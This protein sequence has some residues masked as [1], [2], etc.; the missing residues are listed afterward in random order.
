MESLREAE[1]KYDRDLQATYERLDGYF[2]RNERDDAIRD[3]EWKSLKQHQREEREQFFADGRAAFKTVRNEVYRDIREQFREDWRTTTP[4]P[5][6][7]TDRE[8][9][10]NWKAAIIDLQAEVF[11]KAKQEAFDDLRARRGEEYVELLAEQKDARQD[12]RDAQAQG[13]RSYELLDIIT[14]RQSSPTMTP[15]RTKR[16]TRMSWTKPTRERKGA[17]K[18]T[19]LRG[20][21]LETMRACAA[22]PMWSG[23]SGLG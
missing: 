13:R 15:T 12:L 21:T 23:I 22:A 18:P 20:P 4:P 1:R 14:T 3:N 6:P 11:D 17:R 16:R 9:L 2:S 19:R 8:M 7:S 10:D 5:A